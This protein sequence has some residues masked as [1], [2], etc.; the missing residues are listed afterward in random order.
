MPFVT[1]REKKINSISGQALKV[2]DFLECSFEGLCI[3]F[4]SLHKADSVKLT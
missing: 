4:M 2:K 1:F 3:C